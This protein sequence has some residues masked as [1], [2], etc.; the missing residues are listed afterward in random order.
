VTW[1]DII[2]RKI[3]TILPDLTVIKGDAEYD[4]MSEMPVSAGTYQMRERSMSRVQ[5]E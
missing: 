3:R 5:G 2:I 4:E 1:Y